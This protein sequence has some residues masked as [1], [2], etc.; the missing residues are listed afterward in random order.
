[1][2]NYGESNQGKAPKWLRFSPALNERVDRE[3]FR[4]ELRVENYPNEQ[5]IYNIEAGNHT[6]HKK[7]L[8]TW[9]HIGQ[10][11]FNE[12]VTSKACDTRLHFAHPL[13]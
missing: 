12:S 11:V 1:M 8:A 2:A 3:D 9:Q 7:S 5:L 10:L 4:D 13:N 6:R